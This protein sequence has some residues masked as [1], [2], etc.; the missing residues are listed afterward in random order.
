MMTFAK[1]HFDNA[2][3]KCNMTE[4]QVQEEIPFRR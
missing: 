3:D 1:L 4:Q 2:K